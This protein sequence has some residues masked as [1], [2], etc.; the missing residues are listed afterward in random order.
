MTMYNVTYTRLFYPKIH[1]V[2]AILRDLYTWIN[3]VASP[4]N[5]LQILAKEIF[6]NSM[7]LISD[8]RGWVFFT[9]IPTI[10]QYVSLKL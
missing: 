9:R 10:P 1:E 5:L 8:W 2:P 6:I 4:T 3:Q 7:E